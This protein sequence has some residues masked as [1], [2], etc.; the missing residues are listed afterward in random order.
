MSSSGKGRDVLSLSDVVHPAFPLPTTAAPTLRGALKDGFW[1]GCCGKWA[2]ISV[3]MLSTVVLSI[4]MQHK[5]SL[6]LSLSLSSP[7]LNLSEC[8][9]NGSL[10]NNK[11]QK[12]VGS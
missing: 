6:S 3:C 12:R 4:V 2:N 8:S 5:Y 7:N 9:H 1:R 10:F 11:E